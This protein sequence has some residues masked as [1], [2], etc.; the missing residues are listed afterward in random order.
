MSFNAYENSVEAV[1]GWTLSYDKIPADTD[2]D[3]GNA[4]RRLTKHWEEI[5]SDVDGLGGLKLQKPDYLAL[6]E[7]MIKAK[8]HAIFFNLVLTKSEFRLDIEAGAITLK[9]GSVKAPSDLEEY[10]NFLAAISGWSQGDHNLVPESDRKAWND[11]NPPPPPKPNKY[12]TYDDLMKK[13]IKSEVEDLRA[14][15]KGNSA[16]KKAMDVVDK[17]AKAKPTD[18]ARVQALKDANTAYLAYLKTF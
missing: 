18:P 12:K 1:N 6:I 14:W 7:A 9:A 16:G 11:K 3:K 13:N 15:A 4:V 2:I 5:K 10:R 8:S 17:T